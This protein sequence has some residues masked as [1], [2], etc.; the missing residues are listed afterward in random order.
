MFKIKIS[1]NKIFSY[2]Y[3]ASALFGIII[4]VLVTLFLY[5]NFYK[6]IT[7][8]QKILVLRREVV[9]EDIDINRFDEIIKKIE[10]KTRARQSGIFL[11]F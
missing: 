2:F 9:T 6:T 3:I 10:E 7:N 5:K 4:L 11:R 1:Y 8:S